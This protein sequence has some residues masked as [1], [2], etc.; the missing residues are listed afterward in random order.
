MSEKVKL[1]L[2]DIVVMIAILG[3][4][5]T[6]S[7]SVIANQIHS[8]KAEKRRFIR[9]CV[10]VEQ[11]GTVDCLKSWATRHGADRSR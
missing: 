4:A 7:V 1:F 6:V 11:R 8:V 3:A 2:F 9:Q 10:R 5:L